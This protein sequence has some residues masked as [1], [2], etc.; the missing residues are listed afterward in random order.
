MLLMVVVVFGLLSF[1]GIGVRRRCGDSGGS[2]GHLSLSMGFLLQFAFNSLKL[3]QNLLLLRNVLIIRK[4]IFFPCLYL[5]QKN[6]H[7]LA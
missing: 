5:I 6:V 4:T 7:I 2:V 3:G 1:G